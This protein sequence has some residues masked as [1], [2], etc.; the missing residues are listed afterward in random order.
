MRSSE[1][2]VHRPHGCCCARPYAWLQPERSPVLDENAS[3][4]SVPYRTRVAID[5]ADMALAIAVAVTKNASQL[6]RVSRC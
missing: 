2:P 3:R 6:M 4:L 1:A 5:K